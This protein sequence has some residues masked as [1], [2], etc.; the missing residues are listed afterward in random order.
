MFKFRIISS[1]NTIQGNLVFVYINPSFVISNHFWWFE[2]PKHNVFMFSKFLCVYV[3][4]HGTWC[5]CCCFYVLN[6]DSCIVA[7]EFILGWIWCTNWYFFGYVIACLVTT[8][9]VGVDIG[10]H[11][12]LEQTSFLRSFIILF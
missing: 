9:V 3:T 1:A 8:M 10:T 12:A 11:D 2:I 4:F 5:L 7:S 6:L